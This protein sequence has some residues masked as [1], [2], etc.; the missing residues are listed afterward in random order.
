MLSALSPPLT[1]EAQTTSLDR[2][3]P[4]GQGQG[5]QSGPPASCT[6]SD[7]RDS[8][9]CPARCYP[10]SPLDFGVRAPTHGT[11]S[12]AAHGRK[13]RRQ[14]AGGEKI[15]LVLPRNGPQRAALVLTLQDFRDT[16]LSL[17]P[18]PRL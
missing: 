5:E 4:W 10:P 3:L 12:G 13:D 6:G 11:F 2:V 8:A 14:E 7:S 9:P 1:S 17:Q 18:L 16:H 15:L